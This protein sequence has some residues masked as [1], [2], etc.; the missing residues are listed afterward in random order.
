MSNV[1]NFGLAG[2]AGSVQLGKG[3][4]KLASES[5][6]IT[7]KDAAGTL[8]P[9]QGA[10]P[11]DPNDLAPKAYVDAINGMAI[12]LGTPT[13]GS[14]AGAIALTGTT[15]VTNAVDKLNEILAKLVPSA[16][17][18]FPNGVAL[19][20]ASV[21]GA[22][23]L[24]NGAVPNNTAGG[25]IPQTAGQAVVRVTAA[26]VSSNV[27]GTTNDIGPGDSGTVQA[28]VNGT[29]VD[30]QVMSTGS[31]N[32]AGVLT[33][34]NDQAYPVSTP[35]FWESFQAQIVGATAVQGWNRLKLNHTGAGS[36]NDVYFVRDNVTAIPVVSVGTVVEGTA[37]TKAFSSGIPHY[38]TGGILT[39]GFNLTN[40]SGETY[41]SGTIMSVAASNSI[42]TT[43]NYAAGQGGLSSPIARQTSGTSA[44]GL[45]IPVNGTNVHNSGQITASV[46]NPNGT[47]SLAIGPVI[48][49]KN[50]AV[51]AR[52]DEMNIPVSIAVNGGPSATVA[53]RVD[54]TDGSNPADNKQ[55]LTAGDFDS[56]AVTDAWDAAVVGGVLKHDVA[57]YTTGYLPVGPNR[58]TYNATQYA[59]FLIRRTAVSKFDISVVGTYT[60]MWVK[61]PGLSEPYTSSQN[62]W[63]DMKTLYGGAGIPGN[64]GGANGSIGCALGAVANGSGTG[65]WTAT[66]GTLSST[67][68]S[69]NLILVRFSLTAGQAITALS[70]TPA[71][72]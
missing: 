15:T 63:Y 23:L 2:V 16:P 24:A 29:V 3:G 61:L 55:A 17:N 20:V 12:Q 13:D 69:N 46:T 50:G 6:K 10:M 8:V 28:L 45:S 43:V 30:S 31:N 41:S 51:G 66:F 21:G 35:G 5:G 60:G 4:S 38:G 7:A 9:V 11:T 49:V 59:T 22:A 37:G 52:I 34:T 19:T 47:G 18:N 25:T 39:V 44:S 58:S 53:G 40:L 71:T 54:M 32:K 56:T 27:I 14:L 72:R 67:S 36:T 33:I 48:L 57:N 68:A 64:Q 65:S 26:T 62:G 1:K 42:L 70:F